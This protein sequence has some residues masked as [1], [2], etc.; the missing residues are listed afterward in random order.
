MKK[1]A[2]V[3]GYIASKRVAYPNL[4]GGV[5]AIENIYATNE[6]SV[7]LTILVDQ[8]AISPI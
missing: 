4:I 5:T 6:L 1:D 8:K 7:P 2:T 3:K